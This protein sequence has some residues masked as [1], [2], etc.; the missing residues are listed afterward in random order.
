MALEVRVYIGIP[1]KYSKGQVCPIQDKIQEQKLYIKPKYFFFNSS[2]FV[3]NSDYCGVRTSS[4][5]MLNILGLAENR[6]LTCSVVVSNAFNCITAA[7]KTSY[8]RIAVQYKTIV[9]LYLPLFNY[10]KNSS[11]IEN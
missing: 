1:L 6:T 5:R 7:P 4:F 3:V 11:S 9:Y 10:S 2:T 8:Y